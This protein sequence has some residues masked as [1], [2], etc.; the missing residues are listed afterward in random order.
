[1]FNKRVVEACSIRDTTKGELK[2]QFGNPNNI[3]KT[4]NSMGRDF[5]DTFIVSQMIKKFPCIS[6]TK[7]FINIFSHAQY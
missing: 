5:T 2:N 6:D 1:L 7:I 4:T 3:L